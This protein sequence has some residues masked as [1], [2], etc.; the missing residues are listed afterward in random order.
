LEFASAVEQLGASVNSE[1]GEDSSIVTVETLARNDDGAFALFADAALH[2]AFAA[3][4]IERVRASRQTT[5]LQQKDSPQALVAQIYAKVLFANGP[6]G[7]TPLG[8]EAATKAATRDDLSG[9]WKKTAVPSNSALVIAGDLSETEA[10]ALAEKY[11]GAWTGEKYAAPVPPAP[12]APSPAVYI[13]DKPGSPQTMLFAVGVGAAR[14]TPD[15]APLTVMN[16]ILGGLF[17]SRLNMN[18][19]E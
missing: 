10:R 7:Y 14:T 17:S 6:Y 16:T 19:R 5:L 4:E 9:L 3:D 8:T 1:A 18:L 15:F 12:A 2:P 11:F 13:S